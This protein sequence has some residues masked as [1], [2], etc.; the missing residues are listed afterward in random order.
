MSNKT[1]HNKHQH[2]FQVKSVLPFCPIYFNKKADMG[3]RESHMNDACWTK[4][5]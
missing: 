5:P 2:P 3:C 1:V 4:S